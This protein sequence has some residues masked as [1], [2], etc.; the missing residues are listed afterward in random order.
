MDVNRVCKK[1]FCSISVVAD[2]RITRVLQAQA[3][4][5]ASHSDKRG[6]H[7]PQN[8]TSQDKIKI[9]KEHIESLAITLDKIIQ[10]TRTFHQGS[11]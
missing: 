1:A 7:K 11:A 6:R 10:T 3:G 4:V 2:G 9:V 8:K 5:G